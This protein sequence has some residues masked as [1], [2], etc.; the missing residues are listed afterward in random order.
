M[1]NEKIVTYTT[2]GNY[3]HIGVCEKMLD[4][5]H[6]L[7]GG[8][9]GAGKSVLIENLMYTIMCKYTPH[10]ARFFLI[11]S[12]RVTFTKFRRV[13][14]VEQIETETGAILQ[15][16]R[17]I[18]A[19]METRYINLSNAGLVRYNGEHIFVII[20][21]IAD[22]MTIDD[23]KKEF[24]R[25]VQR[26]AQLGRASNIHLIIATQCP[27]RDIIPAKIS[28]NFCGRVALRCLNAIE[29]RQLINR[30]GAETLP[31][32]GRCIYLHCDGLYYAG[33]IPYMPD[34]IQNV[35][36]FWLKQGNND[37]YFI[38]HSLKCKGRKKERV[39]IFPV[40]RELLFGGRVLPGAS[41]DKKSDID[42]L[43]DLSII[44]D[45]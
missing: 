17:D 19:T 33:N 8:T 18:V 11:D 1:D 38:S 24:I 43:N 41:V 32:Y 28:V 23:I 2:P 42:T 14:F 9:T 5:P 44:D 25:L 3:Y 26:I 21:E 6:I 15:L 35:I 12:K 20:D 34:E 10:N 27:A 39:P 7:I 30:K 40:L 45:D 4:S 29:S 13:P 36:D 37:D 22:L 31:Q 16:L